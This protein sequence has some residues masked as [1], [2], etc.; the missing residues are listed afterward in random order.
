M[1]GRDTQALT[2]VVESEAGIDLVKLKSSTYWCWDGAQITNDPHFTVS[3][4]AHAPFWEYV[5][6]QFSSESGGKG[7][8]S[9]SDYAQGHFKFC[10]LGICTHSYPSVSKQQD[11]NGNSTGSTR[12]G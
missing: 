8:W 10:L 2:A 9:H 11:G 6:I 5:G 12:T 4:S 7:Q 1:L 3:G